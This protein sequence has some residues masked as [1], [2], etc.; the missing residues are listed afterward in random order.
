[1]SAG[2]QLL[3]AALV[4]TERPWALTDDLP[5]DAVTQMLRDAL[6]HAAPDAPGQL[7]RLA[8]AYGVCQRAGWSAPLAPRPPVAASL[9]ETRAVAN[10]A[11]SHLLLQALTLGPQRLQYQV[12]ASM[13]QMALRTPPAVLPTLLQAGRQN[14]DLRVRVLPVLG[15]RGRWL[16]QQNS[17]WA[18]A[19]GV[20]EQAD[21]QTQWDHGS[22]EQRCAVLRGERMGTPAAARERLQADWD[23]L[24]AKDRGNL[25][26]TL[27]TGLSTDDEAFLTTQLKDRAQEVRARA[28]DLLAALPTSDYS[29]RMVAR[30]QP[31]LTSGAPERSL[32]IE[33]P[34][35]ADTSW[36]ADQLEAERPKYETLGERAW[37]LFQL[38]SRSPL[39]WWCSHTGLEPATLVALAQSGDWADALLRGW[40]HALQCQGDAAWA[41]ALLQSVPDA[42][43]QGRAAAL[44]M[45]SP[46]QR[47]A[48]LLAQ[49]EQ[50][51]QLN[52]VA[53]SCLDACV[54]HAYL[55]SAV[56]QRLAKLL[57]QRIDAGALLNDYALRNQLPEWV[58]ALHP[59]ALPLL[60][61]LPRSADETASLSDCM[62]LLAHVVNS[63]RQM[64]SL[65]EEKPTP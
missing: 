59:S 32:V 40:R 28:A 44:G 51:A 36:K 3:R 5:Q 4:G 63:R 53:A 37:W 64:Y 15:E 41:L 33:A 27:Q 29:Q 16:A 47:E 8:G 62:V 52:E 20:Q 21:S 10:A 42:R 31:L 54:P 9:P 49:L 1:M 17:E 12:L 35:A 19:C 60:A 23:A 43:W 65:F 2:E 11:W 6:A 56:S 55:G 38:A 45:L 18:Y 39:S 46:A 24:A 58:C 50:S 22:L 57:R 26:A 7:L 25:L 13:D 61:D 48:F 30:L 14:L 34:E